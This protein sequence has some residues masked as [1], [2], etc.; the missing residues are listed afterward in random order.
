MLRDFS[1]TERKELPFLVADAVDAVDAVIRD[2]WVRAQERVNGTR[3]S[4]QA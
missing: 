1:G 2:G 4:R 3:K